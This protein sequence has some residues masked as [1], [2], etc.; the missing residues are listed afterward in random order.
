MD[1]DYICVSAC[2][3]SNHLIASSEEPLLP[4][5]YN[6]TTWTW[7]DMGMLAKQT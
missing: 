6:N 7:K 5:Y 1:P 2:S 3:E 4:A